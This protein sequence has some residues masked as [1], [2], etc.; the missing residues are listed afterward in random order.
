MLNSAIFGY[1]CTAKSKKIN[2]NKVSKIAMWVIV[3]VFVFTACNQVKKEAETNKVVNDEKEL[4]KEDQTGEHG[5]DYGYEMAMGAYQCP[6]KCEGEKTY[7]EEGNCP[8]CKM[9]L[10]KVETPLKE[11]AE[12]EETKE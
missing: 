6:M 7:T 12:A 3:F 9:D 11:E 1:I 8:K 10:K 5:H 2:M 4:K